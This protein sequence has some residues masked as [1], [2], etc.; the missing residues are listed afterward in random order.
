M[1]KNYDALVT[2]PVNKKILSS[3]N[4]KFTGHTE[5]ISKLCGAK[6]N[7]VM[8][9]VNDKLRV[10]LVTTHI[11]LIDIPKLITKKN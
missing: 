6:N 8:M 3:E 9:L 7:E 1:K 5:Y 11:A 4:K 2:L 10:A